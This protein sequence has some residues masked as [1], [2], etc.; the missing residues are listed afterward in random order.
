MPSCLVSYT[1]IVVEARSVGCALGLGGSVEPVAR[2]DV[3]V[4]TCQAGWQAAGRRD[5]DP[6]RRVAQLIS[7]VCVWPVA[8]PGR[9][10]NWRQA[11]KG[12]VP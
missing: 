8:R 12:R 4:A 9:T 11:V 2:C 6:G 5:K 3:R 7:C 1:S 10:G